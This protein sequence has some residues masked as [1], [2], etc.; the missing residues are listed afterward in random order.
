MRGYVIKVEIPEN[1]TDHERLVA[2]A[3]EEIVKGLSRQWNQVNAQI[4]RYQWD[5]HAREMEDDLFQ[6]RAYE[7]FCS[8][9]SALGRDLTAGERRDGG[10]ARRLHQRA[11]RQAGGAGVGP[12]RLQRSYDA[13]LRALE[14]GGEVHAVHGT[15]SVVG[16]RRLLRKV[17]Q[18]AT[19]AQRFSCLHPSVNID[20]YRCLLT[21]QSRWKGIMNCQMCDK[22]ASTY[23]FNCKPRSRWRPSSTAGWVNP[24]PS[25]W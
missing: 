22:S 9:E 15:G 25:C 12:Q 17:V 2:Q 21:K 1:A 23:K 8:R 10:A 20:R 3:K 19:P 14:R 5:D 16:S 24:T 13:T 6:E 4:E 7:E 11:P 18:E